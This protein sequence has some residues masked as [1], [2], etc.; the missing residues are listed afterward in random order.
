MLS[1]TP[2]CL[3]VFGPT[4]QVGQGPRTGRRVFWYVGPAC[5]R[6]LRPWSV[7]THGYPCLT[8]T[9]IPCRALLLPLPAPPAS[10][11]DPPLLG[12]LPLLL[13][14]DIRHLC[15]GPCHLPMA[16]N[17]GS[18]GHG[19]ARRELSPGKGSTEDQGAC[20]AMVVIPL[21][22]PHFP[23]IPTSDAKSLGARDSGTHGGLVAA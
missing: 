18:S 10:T 12:G 5:R 7:G 19:R 16:S 22:S 11:P 4:R 15:G 6:R 20:M 13:V 14:P 17:A 8:L 1:C 23:S 21:R 2:S 9:D 3:H